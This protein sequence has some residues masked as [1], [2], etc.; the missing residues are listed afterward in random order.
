[1]GL[2]NTNQLIEGARNAGTI[3]TYVNGLLKERPGTVTCVAGPGAT[4][5]TITL[6]GGLVEFDS[7]DFSL[8]G[9]AINVDN[10]ASSLRSNQEYVLALVP[11]YDEPVSKVE[12]ET[13]PTFVSRGIN[14]YVSQNEATKEFYTTYFIPTAIQQ[15]IDSF[16][17]WDE[18]SRRA[19]RTGVSGSEKLAFDRYSEQIERLSDPRYT[20]RLLPI[21]GVEFV[22]AEVYPQNNEGQAD[23]TLSM[24]QAEF[25]Y[26]LACQ[27]F[28]PSERLNPLSPYTLT[29]ATAGTFFTDASATIGLPVAPGSKMYRLSSIALYSSSLNAASNIDPYVVSYPTAAS[30]AEAYAYVTA[31]APDGLGWGSVFAMAYEYYQRTNNVP[32]QTGYEDGINKFITKEQHR[33]L[34]RINPVYL[35]D[36][37]A[38]LRANIGMKNRPALMWYADP[39]YLVKFRTAACTPTT[40]TLDAT[41]NGGISYKFMDED[42]IGGR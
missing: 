30:L 7:R 38:P 20:G 35:G 2:L 15:Q 40:A 8:D 3:K 9:L 31:A 24:S 16:G 22:L 21:T 4:A 37:Y 6:E 1:M 13:D 26:F 33:V 28:V 29:S 23:A 17:G 27:S 5:S 41:F 12:A 19:W 32:G 36:P 10:V 18:V 14:Y 25:E 39:V 11:K 34:G 42:E